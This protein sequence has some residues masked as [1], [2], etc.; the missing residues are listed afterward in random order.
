[1]KLLI[2]ILIVVALVDLCLLWLFN[3]QWL[4][5]LSILLGAI[6]ISTGRYNAEVEWQEEGCVEVCDEAEGG[7]HDVRSG[8]LRPPHPPQDRRHAEREE[9]AE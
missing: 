7:E 8:L 3:W 6:M 4:A 1:M 9:V 2:Y 5:G